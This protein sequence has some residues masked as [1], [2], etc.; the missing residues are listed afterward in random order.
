MAVRLWAHVEAW[1]VSIAARMREEKG[2]E[3]IEWIALAAVVLVLLGGILA[4][5]SDRASDIANAIVT[6]ILSWIGR[7]GG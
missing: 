4:V 1:R 6:Q 7:W 2:I 3:T 5:F